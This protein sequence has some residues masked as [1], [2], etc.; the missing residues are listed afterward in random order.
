[1]T[2]RIHCKTQDFD[3]TFPFNASFNR[4]WQFPLVFISTFGFDEL[5]RNVSPVMMESLGKFE[6]LRSRRLPQAVIQLAPTDSHCCRSSNVAS[7]RAA[8][9]DK[10]SEHTVLSLGSWLI[11]TLT[12]L[13]QL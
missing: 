9:W 12:R 6:N 8:Q 13:W 7:V 5:A 10:N 1:M 2:G 3:V 11:L 4:G